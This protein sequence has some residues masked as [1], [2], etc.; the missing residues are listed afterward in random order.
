MTTIINF[1]GNGLS[2]RVDQSLEEVLE[3]MSRAQGQP[4]P[5]KLENG[6]QV[7]INPANIAC[8]QELVEKISPGRLDPLP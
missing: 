5:L 3:A 6:G 1:T 2:V 7:F 8:W 4:F